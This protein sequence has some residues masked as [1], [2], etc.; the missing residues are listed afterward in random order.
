[1]TNDED[2]KHEMTAWAT[3]NGF[4][5]DRTREWEWEWTSFYKTDITLRFLKDFV[6]GRTEEEREEI[7][8]FYKAD[9]RKLLG[10]LNGTI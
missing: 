7:L 9:I 2:L 4:I 10:E 5:K 1:M 3:A 6:K 8:S